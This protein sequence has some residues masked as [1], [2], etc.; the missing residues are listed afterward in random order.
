MMQS[1]R[2][3]AH[4]DKLH[5]KMKERKKQK[6]ERD[7]AELRPFKTKHKQNNNKKLICFRQ[8]FKQASK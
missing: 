3:H 4:L 8:T 5:I 1:K 2:L 6:N 7:E